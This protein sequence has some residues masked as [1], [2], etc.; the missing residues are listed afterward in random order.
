MHNAALMDCGCHCIN[1][2]LY[3]S[4][5][6]AIITLVHKLILQFDNNCL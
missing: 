5:I 6:N 2:K 1:A 4:V 3:I